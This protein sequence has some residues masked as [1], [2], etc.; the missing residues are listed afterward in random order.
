MPI[1]DVIKL[2]KKIV[3]YLKPHSKKIKLV[4]SIR[5]K[6]KNPEDIDVVLIPRDIDKLVSF[7]K[8]KG[9]FMQGGKHESTWKVE[10]T[11]VELYYTLPEEWGA[12]LLAYSSKRGSGI[13]LR[14]IAKKKGFKLKQS[15]IV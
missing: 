14:V 8:K 10:G 9:K 7:M 12:A 1:K 5:R 13:G 6:E 15:R 2:S 11:K 3:Q 4:G